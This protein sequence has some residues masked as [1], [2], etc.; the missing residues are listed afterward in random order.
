MP[1]T[2]AITMSTRQMPMMISH[3]HDVF[4]GGRTL[5]AVCNGGAA[6]RGSQFA[7]E[8]VAMGVKFTERVGRVEEGIELLQRF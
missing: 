5:L 2:T 7:T 8:L 3:S 4:S 6:S 1:Q